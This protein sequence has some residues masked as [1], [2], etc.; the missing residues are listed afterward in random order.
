[1]CGRTWSGVAASFLGMWVVMMAAMMIPSLV[2]ML[3]RYR[4][5]IRRSGETRLGWLTVLA[6]AGY[7]LV[8]TA[9]GVAVFPLGV[10]LTAIEMQ[11]A[12]FARLVPVMIGACVLFAG[13]LQF[14]AWK[15]RHLACCREMRLLDRASPV[16]VGSAWRVGLRLGLHC[17][18]CCAGLTV[19]LLVVGLMDL[20]VMAVVMTA[21]TIER[22]APSGIRAARAIGLL[23][24]GAGL[25]LMALAVCG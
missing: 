12:A 19:C 24:G 22:L 23:T 18:Y 10:A 14:T 11:W 8:W 20:R 5:A 21:I 9:L 2:P 7:F 25:V 16:G 3:C 6:A 13:M 17:S 15:A 4:L 1:M